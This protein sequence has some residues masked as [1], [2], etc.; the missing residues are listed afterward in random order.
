MV[1]W[2]VYATHGP[3]HLGAAAKELAADS[4]GEEV[5][6]LSPPCHCPST[7]LH[8]C[9]STALPLPLTGV[10]LPFRHLSPPSHRPFSLA[11]L[12]ATVATDLELLKVAVVVPIK[13]E[14]NAGPPAR[15]CARTE[16]RRAAAA[17][18]ASSSAAAGGPA[19]LRGAA[20]AA[21]AARQPA[22][23][24]SSA[25]AAPEWFAPNPKVYLMR[26]SQQYAF[27]LGWKRAE[28]GAWSKTP[29]VGHQLLLPPR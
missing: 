21:A 17:G 29:I 22:E 15:R 11:A 12:Q 16:P 4:D 2:T 13:P 8:R 14:P 27:E 1:H 3:N 25:A 6:H 10:S 26:Y 9:P 5:G 28:K 20:A 7:A 24:V 23:M 18:R 19:G